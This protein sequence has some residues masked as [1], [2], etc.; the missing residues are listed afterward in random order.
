MNRD[1]DQKVNGHLGPKIF[2]KDPTI[3][4]ELLYDLYSTSSSRYF[5]TYH[6]KNST[7]KSVKMFI[8]EGQGDPKGCGGSSA[9][10]R[11]S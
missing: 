4:K 2:L 7:K 11:T 1:L 5:S 8:A 6:V 9:A 3:Q 10:V